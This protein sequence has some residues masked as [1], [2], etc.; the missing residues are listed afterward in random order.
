MRALNEVQWPEGMWVCVGSGT[1]SRS[2]D[3][4][5]TLNDFQRGQ[6]QSR[7]DPSKKVHRGRI[8]KSVFN[9]IFTLPQ[10]L[11]REKRCDPKRDRKKCLSVN[12]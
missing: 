11:T 5:S 4:R 8:Y 3:D 7:A 2:A 1:G 12:I 9:F 10:Y 6:Q